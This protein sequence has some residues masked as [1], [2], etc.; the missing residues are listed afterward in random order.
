MKIEIKN[1][2]QPEIA[3]IKGAVLF[4]FKNN[5]I[6]KRKAKYTV[7]IRCCKDWNEKLHKDKGIQKN[8]KLKGLQCSNL[9][10]KFITINQYIDFDHVFTNKYDAIDPN[11]RIVFYK[12][13]KEDCTFIDEKDENN[14]PIIKEFGN[15]QLNLGE[16]YDKNKHRIKINMRLGGTYIVVSAIYLETKLKIEDVFNYQDDPNYN[17]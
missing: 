9:F 15:I 1:P 14:N 4:G 13:L 7:G 5:I 2:S 12:T 3:I 10:S 6:K 11:P 17:K 8:N 16:N